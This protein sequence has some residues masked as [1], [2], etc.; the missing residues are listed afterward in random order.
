MPPET[1]YA[2]TLD[3]THVAYQVSGDGP[4][5]IL[6][7]RAWHSN[8]D[9]DWEDPVLAGVQRRLGA[10]GRVIRLDRRGT[11][12]SDRLDPNELP[13]VEARVDDMRAVLDAAGSER[14]VLI[15]LAHGAALCAVFAA[16]YPERTAG[17]VMYSPPSM[18]VGQDDLEELRAY[19]DALVETWGMTGGQPWVEF[20]APSR[21]DDAAFRDW[22][23]DDQ[24]ASGSGLEAAAQ[25]RLVAETN[26]DGIL[27]SI[28][29]PTL[30]LWRRGSPNAGPY[31]AQR[32]AG[33]TAT[34]LPGE[35]HIMIS[36]DT[37]PWL[38]AVEA[39]VESVRS[40]DADAD[41]VLATVMFTDV[42]GSTQRAVALGDRGWRDLVERHHA[43]VRREL[44]R[45]RGREIDVAGDGF[46]AAFDGP[47]RAIRCA[48]AVRETAAAMDLRLRIGVHAGECERAGHGLRGI[49][50]H[51]G[52]R[53]GASAEPDEILV[54]STVHDLVAGSGIG[55]EDAGLRTLKD[56]PQPWHLY[57]VRG[58]GNP[59]RNVGDS[60]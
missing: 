30:V 47:G 31:V 25:F 49:A 33:A 8:L 4:V 56:V 41:R 40:L 45:F 36:G 53:I 3:G 55:F 35:D 7:L 23:R 6:M 14:A 28:H 54:S 57:R 29:V 27:S 1:R 50:V 34:E 15:G 18:L 37:R 52:A 13:T 26:I 48:A 58:L 32:I 24:V 60:V 51:V 21:S 5:D 44:A 11:G 22:I 46:F 42:V 10:V 12:L 43:A 9:H 17:L 19:G 2:R 59:D 16:T 20:A 38:A 39:F